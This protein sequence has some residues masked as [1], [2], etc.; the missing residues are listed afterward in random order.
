MQELLLYLS[1]ETRSGD[2]SGDVPLRSNSV[3]KLNIPEMQ[4]RL[5][6][7]ET[8][9]AAK[10][11]LSREYNFK[12][13]LSLNM[14]ICDDGDDFNF[15]TIALYN[16]QTGLGS[17]I[18]GSTVFLRIDGIGRIYN[19]RIAYLEAKDGLIDDLQFPE[20]FCNSEILIERGLE[21]F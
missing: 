21:G 18:F 3:G 10:K 17:R 8:R 16:F 11:C 14:D 15:R 12:S 2:S 1:Y 9:R 5:V 4:W 7:S 19:G 20:D 13:T 6:S